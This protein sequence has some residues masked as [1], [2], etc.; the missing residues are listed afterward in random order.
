MRVEVNGKEIETEASTLLDLVS[1]YARLEAKV[2]TALNG[3][4]IAAGDRAATRLKSGDKVEIVSPR[5]GG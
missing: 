3:Q 2:A 5:Q 4:F 1:E